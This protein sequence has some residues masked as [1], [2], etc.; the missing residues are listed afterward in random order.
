MAAI[1]PIPPFPQL[2]DRAAG[3]YNSKSY[4]FGTHL[5][6]VFP[7][8]AN[9]LVLEVNAAALAAADAATSASESAGQAGVMASD[10]GIMASAAEANANFKGR[11]A[12]LAG[13]LALPASVAHGGVTWQL[14]EPAANVAAEVPGVS[15]KWQ[16]VSPY[17]SGDTIV[18]A[19]ALTP[20]AWLPCDGALYLQASYPKLFAVLGLLG[21][22]VEGDSPWTS[23]TISN[24]DY[25]GIT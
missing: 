25:K 8:E 14:L 4:A 10:A 6:D 19:R 13:A 2:A 16:A 17:M 23:R 21:S 9:A 3:V 1:S 18:T 22:G 7:A 20:P 15:A 5:A 12:A 11:W 24:G